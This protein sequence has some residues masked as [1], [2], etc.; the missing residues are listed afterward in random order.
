MTSKGIGTSAGRLVE[1]KPIIDI[2]QSQATSDNFRENIV[3]SES[4]A[5]AIEALTDL[6]KFI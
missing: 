6:D 3:Y 5:K 1:D 4:V 2:R